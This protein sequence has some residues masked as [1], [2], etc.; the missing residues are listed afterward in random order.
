MTL[1]FIIRQVVLW[2]ALHIKQVR[3]CRGWFHV[4]HNFPH[5]HFN[6]CGCLLWRRKKVG[7]VWGNFLRR[8][9]LHKGH[10]E[11]TFTLSCSFFKWRILLSPALIC[12]S[13]ATLMKAEV[14]SFLCL[15]I[16]SRL[17]R[18][19]KVKHITWF[20]GKCHMTMTPAASPKLQILDQIKPWKVFD[21]IAAYNMNSVV[22]FLPEATEKNS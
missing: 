1:D 22:F 5:L 3:D 17:L 8:F 19:D 12:N 10:I 16:N 18:N 11:G 14:I 4:G 2:C 6:S 9:I 15:D 20:S 21:S 13:S 7:R